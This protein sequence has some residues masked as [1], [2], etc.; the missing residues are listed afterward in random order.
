MVM[1]DEH[2]QGTQNS[3]QW[4]DCKRKEEGKK[5]FLSKYETLYKAY[6]CV[7]NYLFSYGMLYCCY[8]G[9]G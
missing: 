4:K 3:V 7:N 5:I 9:P 6:L 1:A 8:F 2:K